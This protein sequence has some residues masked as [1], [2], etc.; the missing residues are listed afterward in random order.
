MTQEVENLASVLVQCFS[1]ILGGYISGRTGIISET[2]SNDGL[3]DGTVFY[4]DGR[5]VKGATVYA[6]ALGRPIAAIIPH[7]D[8]DET[9]YFTIRISSSWFGRFAVAAKKEDE[10]YP[11]MSS[12]FYSDGKFETVTLTPAHPFSNARIH[13]GPKAGV[14]EG[15]VTDAVTG[16]P[17]RPCVEFKRSA[18]PSNFMS[19][20]GIVKESYR[21]FVPSDTDV[22]LKIWLDGY[23]PW[24]F[25]GTLRESERKGVR[26]KPGE[27]TS[28]DISLQADA[29]YAKTGCPAPIG[30]T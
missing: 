5:V 6:V 22:L 23:K 10:D 16:A 9:G 20:S 26:L 28:L 1:L 27:H 25:P 30:S 17:L 18:N 3:I 24:Y 11:D 4:D 14:L 8:T 19:G 21:L 2:E 15:R 7:A 29:K 12:Q 13:L